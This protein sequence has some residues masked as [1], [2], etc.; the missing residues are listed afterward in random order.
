[1]VAVLEG[2]VGIVSKTNHKY[3]INFNKGAR[4]LYPLK[5]HL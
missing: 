4:H 5:S 1:M 2:E 3:D